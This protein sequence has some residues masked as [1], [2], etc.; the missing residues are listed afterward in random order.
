MFICYWINASI[1]DGDNAHGYIRQTQTCNRRFSPS[2]YVA[3]M[4]NPSESLW[5][6][7]NTEYPNDKE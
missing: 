5:F 7:P 1:I 3:V 4:Y 2:D 6:V